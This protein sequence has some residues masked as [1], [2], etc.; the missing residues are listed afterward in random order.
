MAQECHFILHS[1]L[2]GATQHDRLD[3]NVN[4]Q[5]V[6]LACPVWRSGGMDPQDCPLAGATKNASRDS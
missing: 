4:V 5:P 1:M 2:L 6:A 3:P